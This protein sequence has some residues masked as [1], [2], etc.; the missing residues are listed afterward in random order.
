MIPAASGLA[1]SAPTPAVAAAKPKAAAAD[2]VPDALVAVQKAVDDLLAA[3]TSLDVD[4]IASA[5]TGVVD[6]LLDLL[7]DWVPDEAARARILVA[8]PAALYGFE[9]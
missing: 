6:G 4:E 7:P 5:V 3:A 9:D 1:D 8:N 2:P